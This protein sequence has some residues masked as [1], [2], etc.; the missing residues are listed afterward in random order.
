VSGGNLNEKADFKVITKAELHSARSHLGAQ[1]NCLPILPTSTH[2]RRIH[3]ATAKTP[4]V[5]KKSA[6][7]QNPCKATS[8]GTAMPRLS[9]EIGPRNC[10]L[11]SVWAGEMKTAKGN[12]RKNNC[13]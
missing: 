5:A 6:K 13:A 10:G 4:T 8:V 11:S 1:N 2:A 7:S 3:S 9:N 12:T